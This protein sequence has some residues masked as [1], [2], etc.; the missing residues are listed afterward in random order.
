MGSNL[1]SS[2]MTSVIYG[3]DVCMQTTKSS[4]GTSVVV[5]GMLLC[6]VDL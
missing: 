1:T 5:V 2:E 4:G 6:L 3:G